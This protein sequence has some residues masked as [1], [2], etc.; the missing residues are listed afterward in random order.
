MKLSRFTY[1]CFNVPFA[2]S[3]TSLPI[4]RPTVIPPPKLIHDNTFP[5]FTSRVGNTSLIRLNGISELTGCNI[6]GKAEW[7]NP[8]GSIKDRAALYIIKEAEK[9]G[10]LTPNEEGIIVEGTAGNTGIGLTMVGNARG[11]QTIM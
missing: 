9:Q 1:S 5:D 4:T 7:E 8:G 10:I 3:Y 2:R 6:Y 11:Y